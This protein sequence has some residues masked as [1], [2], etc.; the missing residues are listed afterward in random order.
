MPFWFVCFIS[1]RPIC[2]IVIRSF[3]IWNRQQWQLAKKMWYTSWPRRRL[4]A[5]YYIPC[6][7]ERVCSRSTVCC[8]TLTIPRVE[9]KRQKHR[10]TKYF[11]VIYIFTMYL[12]EHIKKE[13]IAEMETETVFHWTTSGQ[14]F[15]V[16]VRAKPRFPMSI[17]SSE[18]VTVYNTNGFTL[19]SKVIKEN[20]HIEMYVR[21]LSRT[22]LRFSVCGSSVLSAHSIKS[23][24]LLVVGLSPRPQNRSMPLVNNAPFWLGFGIMM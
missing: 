22:L 23:I 19:P 24:H 11:A 14:A 10:H 18:F 4:H 21:V 5:I 16:Y 8:Y 7:V 15:C 13:K 2:V 20:V 17:A 6:E 1:L 12:C 3:D 9:H